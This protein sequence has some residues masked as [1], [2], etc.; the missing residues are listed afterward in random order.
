MEY[1]ISS[2][3]LPIKM[4]LKEVEPTCMTQI[5][6]LA[7]LPFVFKHIAIMPDSH[8]GYG[9][10]IGGVLATIGVVIP[11]AVGVDIGCGM[12]AIQT[13]I[14]SDEFTTEQLKVIMSKIRQRIPV[15]FDHHQFPQQGVIFL[16]INHL[17]IVLEEY[18]SATHQIGTLGGGNHFIEIQK[19]NNGYIWIMI[20][21]GSRNL[22][23]KVAHHYN[24]LAK[25]LNEK[26]HTSIPKEFD[27]AFFPM[28]SN[29]YD[30]YM[31]EMAYCLD[32]AKVNRDLMMSRIK[33]IFEEEIKNCS[34]T[35]TVNIHHN[36]A[37]LENHF[38]H[39]VMANQADLVKILVELQPLGVIKG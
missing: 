16:P 26:W 36:Y 33:E 29:E 13:S 28:D 21:S 20:H 14:R 25:E 17:D 39:N 38:G 32:F 2:E 37:T 5:K 23:Y 30:C 19:G 4:W 10:P 18:Q 27:L 22:G 1:V 11:N 34:F 9:M 24:E 3:K 35:S 15:G 31:N 12:C 7:N 8:T 6:N